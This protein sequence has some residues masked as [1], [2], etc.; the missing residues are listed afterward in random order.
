MMVGVEVRAH[1]GPGVGR[2][3]SIVPVGAA[4][5]AA[6]GVI[7][8]GWMRWI[9]V[10]PEFTWAGTI[11]IVAAFTLFA[12]GQATAALA[13][14]GSARPGVV[15]ASRCAAAMLSLG[16]FGAAGAVMFPTVLFG[17]LAVWR[18]GANRW[19]RVA[20]AALAMPMV[21]LAILAIADDHGWGVEALGMMVLLL[22]D[23]LQVAGQQQRL[24]VGRAIRLQLG[25]GLHQLDR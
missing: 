17:S 25:H 3:W 16:L 14:T 4:A 20:G 9:S 19:L 21:A 2:R 15:A 24:G 1:V 18:T 22:T 11:G 8:R 23:N 12:A 7:A 13:R 5:G 10:D 6:L